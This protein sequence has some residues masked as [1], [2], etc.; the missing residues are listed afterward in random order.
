MRRLPCRDHYDG[1]YEHP[2]ST[3]KD[4]DAHD[5]PV[6]HRVKTSPTNRRCI[7]EAVTSRNNLLFGGFHRNDDVKLGAAIAG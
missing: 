7:V 1:A 5:Q 6:N 4:H 2:H 3:E